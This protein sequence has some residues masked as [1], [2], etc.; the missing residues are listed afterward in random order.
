MRDQ[1]N[2]PPGGAM[3]AFASPWEVAAFFRWLAGSY[4]G[5]Q[6]D[7]QLAHASQ[8]GKRKVVEIE[9]LQERLAQNKAQLLVAIER[10]RNRPEELACADRP[11]RVLNQLRKKSA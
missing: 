9:Q 3:S 2:W 11:F 6:N 7:R 1:A 10:V 8:D 4:R 5:I